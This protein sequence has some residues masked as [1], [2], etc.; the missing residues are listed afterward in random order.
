MASRAYC[1]FNSI[2]VQLELRPKFFTVIVR[3]FQFHKGS[4]RTGIQF[5]KIREFQRFN[6]IKVQLERPCPDGVL[7]G[8]KFQFHKGAIRTLIIRA[9][10]RNLASVSIP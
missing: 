1:S 10:K 5:R 3:L 6:S 8:T 2:K 7:I 9:K 4:I